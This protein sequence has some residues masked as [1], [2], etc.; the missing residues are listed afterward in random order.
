MVNDSSTPHTGKRAGIGIVVRRLLRA[1][2]SG[3][4]GSVQ[5]LPDL[6]E[7]GKAKSRS[8]FRRFVAWNIDHMGS[9]LC[10][11]FSPS[12]CSLWTKSRAWRRRAH[13]DHENVGARLR[14][15]GRCAPEPPR[16]QR[17]RCHKLWR[18]R[19]GCLSFIPPRRIP[20][21]DLVI[22]HFFPRRSKFLR[23][24]DAEHLIGL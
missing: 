2:L 6:P 1:I 8:S 16:P 24:V 14:Q 22:I 7:W 4:E 9:L 19:P 18:E 23:D 17:A 13:A 5:N 15:P 11:A 10:A 21:S 12:L 3:K 20:S